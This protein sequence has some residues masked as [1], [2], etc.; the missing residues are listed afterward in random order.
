MN[1][2]I[3]IVSHG[4]SEMLS[5]LLHDAVDSNVQCSRLI[6]TKNLP[7]EFDFKEFHI[8]NE[9]IIID[10]SSR[11]GF[12][13]NH[14]SAFEHS[15]AKFFAVLNPD[16][17]FT[18]NPFPALLKNFEDPKVGIVCPVIT[19]DEGVAE[20]STREFPTL[21]NLFFKLLRLAD[22]GVQRAVDKAPTEVDW[23]AGMFLLIRREAMLSIGGF[24]P[25]FFLYYED[26]DLCA[27]MHNGGW[28]IVL[29]PAEQVI[30]L[31]QRRSRRNLRYMLWHLSS[32]LRY[33]RKRLFTNQLI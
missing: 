18:N 32:M 9:T 19:N 24:D 5:K 23:A 26:V 10:N 4:Q 22:G 20:D 6:I 2:D 13:A 3:S 31:A 8:S 21:F 15:D 14:N 30:H 28:K 1:L 12:G 33:F 7:E 29:D 27:R 17:R 25:N 16:L 11:K